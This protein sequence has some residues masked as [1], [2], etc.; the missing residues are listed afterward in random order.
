MAS[1]TPPQAPP[2]WN[3]SADDILSLTKEA[4]AN[5]QKLQDKVGALPPDQCD[6]SSVSEA[7]LQ[8]VLCLRRTSRFS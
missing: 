2:R 6:F 8:F 7:Q 5:E 4:I 1:L 3:H